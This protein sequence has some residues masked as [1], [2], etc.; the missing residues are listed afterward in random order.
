MAF[1]KE[2]RAAPMP[3][4][5]VD[6]NSRHEKLLMS[7]V[8]LINKPAG[9]TSMDVCRV[10]RRITRAKK[11]GHGGTLD[12]F[13]TGVLPILLNGATKISNEVMSGVKEYEGS[14]LLGQAYDTQDITGT[15]IG[16]T[17][18]PPANLDL[19][20]LQRL[21]NEFIGEIQ[22]TPPAFSAVKKQGRPLYDYARKGEKVEVES[23]T[24]KVEEFKIKDF[25]G[26]RGRFYVRCHKGTYVRTLVHDL[27]QRLQCGAVVDQLSRT[28]VGPFKIE[29]AV[30]LS[31]LK[32]LNAVYDVFQPLTAIEGIMK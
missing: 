25:D 3:Q 23:R 17:Q 8:V 28:G 5:V 19:E 2:N 20:S 4:I 11:V 24:V 14:F 31:L 10:M 21:A 22:Q 7:G 15:P 12:P 16:E 13:A 9:L 29:K 32:D 1:W 18:T 30:E 26:R 6:P 27:G